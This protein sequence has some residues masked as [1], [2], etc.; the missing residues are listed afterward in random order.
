MHLP[1]ILARCYTS[2]VRYLVGAALGTTTALTLAVACGARSDLELDPPPPRAEDAGI[3]APVDAPPDVVADAPADVEEDV[4]V[5]PECSG[6]EVT[7]IYVV[8]GERE[9]YA[10]KPQSNSFELKGT[11]F[12]PSA[13]SPFSMAVSR[14]GIARVLYTDGNLFEVDILDAAC[15]PT[16]YQ[17]PDPDDDFFQFGMGYAADGDG[18][19]LFVADITFT[20]PSAGLARIDTDSYTLSY[21]GPFTVNPGNAIELTPTGLDGPLYGYFLNSPPPG[22]TLVQIDTATA[23]IVEHTFV[24]IGNGQSSLAV[25]WWG[26]DFYVFTGTGG[27]T[28][29]TRYDPVAQT[30][31][32]VTTLQNHVV[33]AGVSTCAPNRLP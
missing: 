9:L 27:T 7:Y 18:E 22:G 26:D 6:P 13:A 32:Q 2:V 31:A 16:A 11:L 3:D 33:G 8:T 17:P 25:A 21:I 24:D 14:E 5:P 20:D 23:E 1:P 15:S 29:V 28:A 10:Y 30:V 4:F 12:C 19:S